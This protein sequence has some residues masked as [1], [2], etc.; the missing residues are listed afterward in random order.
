MDALSPGDYVTL[1]T[2]PPDHYVVYALIDPIDEQVYYV[3]Q[4]RNP[5]VRLAAHLSAR[6]HEGEKGDWLRLLEQK[7]QQPLMQILEVVIGQKTALEK[8]Q[9]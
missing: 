3:G 8:E 1:S 9:E 2:L 6:H 4:T 5:Q 7:G